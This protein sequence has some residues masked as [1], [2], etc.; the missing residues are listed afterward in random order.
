MITRIEFLGWSAY[1]SAPRL[2]SQAR[3]FLGHAQE[4]DLSAEIVEQTI[5]LRQ[6]FKTEVS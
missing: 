3:T 4:F 2:Y 1:A 5:R 6:Q